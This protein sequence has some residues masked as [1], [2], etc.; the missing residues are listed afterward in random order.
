MIDIL[1]GFLVAAI[2]IG[3][4]NSAVVMVLYAH[5]SVSMRIERAAKVRDSKAFLG[6]Q[7]GGRAP[8]KAKRQRRKRGDEMR[9]ENIFGQPEKVDIWVVT[10]HD[11]DVTYRAVKS[12]GGID[13]VEG[14][15]DRQMTFGTKRGDAGRCISE[16]HRARNQP[17]RGTV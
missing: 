11:G 6:R 17:L 5:E 8:E 10:D 9:D 4:I 15:V 7:R 16:I 12:G 3:F 1:A 14:S 13:P 2:A